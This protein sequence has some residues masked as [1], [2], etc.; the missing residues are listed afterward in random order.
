[1]RRVWIVGIFMLLGCFAG[2]LLVSDNY[3]LGGFMGAV[4]GFT[5]AMIVFAFPRD[6]DY[7]PSG[8]DFFGMN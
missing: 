1:M 2:F 7:P 3:Q 5:A 6:R 4:G 8:N